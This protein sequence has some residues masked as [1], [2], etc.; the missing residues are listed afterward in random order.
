MNNRWRKQKKRSGIFTV[1]S[2]YETLVV[3]PHESNKCWKIAAMKDRTQY[4]TP[5]FRKGAKHYATKNR[6]R[7]GKC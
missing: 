2:K 4:H 5:S 1:T 6:K 3:I 7:N